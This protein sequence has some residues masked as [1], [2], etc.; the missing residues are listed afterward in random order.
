MSIAGSS[1]LLKFTNNEGLNSTEKE[2]FL[3]SIGLIGEPNMSY[4]VEGF[5]ALL[6]DFGPLWVTTDEN[7]GTGFSIHARIVT[8]LQGDGSP[9]N[10]FLQINDPAGGVEVIE[11]YKDFIQK[12]EDVAGSGF[13]GIQVVHY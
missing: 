11:A 3:S 9:E 5:K 7:P 6:E 1:Y 8:R 12:F 4:S 2:P 13:Q 10:T